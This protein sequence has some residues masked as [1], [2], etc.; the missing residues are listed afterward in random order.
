MKLIKILIA[1]LSSFYLTATLAAETTT[2]SVMTF[3]IEN[4]G[5]QVDFNKVI[6]A[7][8]KS[9]ADIVGI[10]EAWGNTQRIANAL[11]WEYYDPRQHVISKFPLL[12][13]SNS[14]GQYVLV[15][16]TP[17]KVV[18]IANVHLPD[19]PYGPD[20]VRNGASVD[21]VE[22]N[23]R[24]VRLSFIMPVIKKMTA[25]AK[26][27]VP[28]FMTGDLNSPSHLDWINNSNHRYVVSWPVTKTLIIS[29]MTDS[30]RAAHSDPLKLPGVTWPAG[31][32]IVH[33][34]SDNFNP[35]ANDPSDRIDFIFS[36]NASV[37]ASDVVGEQGVKGVGVT[38]SP[39]PSD[40]RAVV[41]RF[42]VVP[43]ALPVA[44]I[45]AKTS[46]LS[47][48]EKKPVISVSKPI[49]KQDQTFSIKWENAPGNGYD[50]VIVTPLV[51]QSNESARFY[52]HATVSGVIQLNAK[53]AIGNW[54]AWNKVNSTWPLKSGV[55]AVK[56]MSDDSDTV[57]AVTQ[58][59]IV[60]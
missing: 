3:N 36:A 57:L 21:V 23:E 17:G 22:A 60:K 28:I 34:T 58:L 9:K 43:V 42:I 1:V 50:Y 48:V 39:W 26:L 31:R 10:Q 52:T 56:L 8:K 20:L 7:I 40:H 19:E 55:Y 16:V 11:G 37:V 45:I 49:V 38:I 54:P 47:N 46:K 27:H 41:S 12:N 4:G 29:G 59:T 30:F 5:T 51:S 6:A 25:L 33:H 32:P 24:K 35:S 13:A 2:I 18:A 53:N 44:N 15:E 14:E